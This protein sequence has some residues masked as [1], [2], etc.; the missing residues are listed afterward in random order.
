MPR[1][2]VKEKILNEI[3]TGATA[4]QCAEK[5]NIP[6]GTIRSW[7]SRM[8]CSA[9]RNVATEKPATQRNKKCNIT[10]T[11]KNK[12]KNDLQ[13]P[14]LQSKEEAKCEKLHELNI[15]GATK[16]QGGGICRNPA[17]FRTPHFGIGR[18]FLHG[19]LST[20]PKNGTGEYS[21]IWLDVLPEDEKE[22]Y[23]EIITDKIAQLD[24][25][26]RLIEIRER[27][28]LQRIENLK[29][30]DFTIVEESEES[31]IEKGEDTHL[32]TIKKRATLGQIQEIEEAL[33]RVQARKERLIALKHKFEEAGEGQDKEIHVYTGIPGVDD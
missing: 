24:Q 22:L 28:M 16:K 1:N 25:E 3:A 18:C 20:G 2:E 6:A 19:G 9:T 31:G 30:A 7:V 33:T 8:K 27:R 15:C 4:K 14:K 32:V 5:Y 26:I 21:A 23:H 12:S 10:K 13:K 29:K 17:G 11:S